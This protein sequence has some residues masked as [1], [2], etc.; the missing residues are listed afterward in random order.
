MRPYS[1]W[2]APFVF[3]AVQIA[4]SRPSACVR[5]RFALPGLIR[6]FVIGALAA[7]PLACAEVIANTGQVEVAAAMMCPVGS[8]GCA[9]TSGGGCDPGLYCDG[10]VCVGGDYGTGDSEYMFE[11]DMLEAEMLAPAPMAEPMRAVESLPGIA[12][13][14]YSRAERRAERNAGRKFGKARTTSADTAAPAGKHD[15]SHPPSRSAAS[16]RPTRSPAIPPS[17]SSR[18]ARPARSST[19][20]R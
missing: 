14:S 16:L 17:P 3:T 18:T 6:I 9:C 7:F 5:A 2:L 11:D 10:G 1:R 4:R 15:G 20:P 12:A 13:G 8:Q 19:P